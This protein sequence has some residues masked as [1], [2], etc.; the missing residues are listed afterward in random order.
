MLRGL[1]TL[2]F[3]Y[4]FCGWKCSALT[5]V[6]SSFSFLKKLFYKYKSP[7]PFG[8]GLFLRNR[9][10]VNPDKP[11]GDR[12]CISVG[13][14]RTGQWLLQCNASWCVPEPPQ[15]EDAYRSAFRRCPYRHPPEYF[16][17]LQGLPMCSMPSPQNFLLHEV[18][19][20]HSRFHNL[21]F[22]QRH[23]P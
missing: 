10:P 18:A 12:Q 16:L 21:C 14:L 1:T 13:F 19:A 20:S 8:T 3:G 17:R 2:T 7:V 11:R 23:A 15:H 9:Q 5:S 22:P 4:N 6:W